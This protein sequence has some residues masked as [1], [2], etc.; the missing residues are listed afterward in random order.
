MPETTKASKAIEARATSFDQI[1]QVSFITG[2]AATH[3]YYTYSAEMT[4]IDSPHTTGNIHI[5]T[6]AQLDLHQL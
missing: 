5:C 1:A 4:T 2:F 3:L 6:I